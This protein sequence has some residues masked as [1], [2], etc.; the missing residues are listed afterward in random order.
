M[1]PRLVSKVFSTMCAYRLSD[2]LCV[3]AWWQQIMKWICTTSVTA[4]ST[5]FIKK[6]M[7][8]TLISLSNSSACLWHGHPCLGSGTALVK[9][10]FFLGGHELLEIARWEKFGWELFLQEI[11][12]NSS[13]LRK[14]KYTTMISLWCPNSITNVKIPKICQWPGR[15]NWKHHQA[16]MLDKLQ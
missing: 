11:Y 8:S 5:I 1:E 9:H 7:P 12:I 3:Q 6:F 2:Y 16:N 10:V 14:Q 4:S 13:H 15:V